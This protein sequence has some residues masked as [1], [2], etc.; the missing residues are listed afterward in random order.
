MGA[1]FPWG[2]Q[3]VMRRFDMELPYH[4]AIIHTIA[5][6]SGHPVLPGHPDLHMTGYDKHSEQPPLPFH[7]Q[8]AVP[9]FIG[10]TIHSTAIVFVQKSV[11]RLD[12]A[13]GAQRIR[14][15]YRIW[16]NV[17]NLPLDKC[18]VGPPAGSRSKRTRVWFATGRGA[19][20][21]LLWLVQQ[22]TSSTMA[23]IF[24]RLKVT[25]DV[26]GP[27]HQ[28]LVPSISTM[29]V[30]GIMSFHWIWTSYYS[31]TTANDL[32]AILFVAILGWDAAEE[33]PPLFGSLADAYTLRRFWGVFW[34]RLHVYSFTLCM[35]S[36]HFS[37]NTLVGGAFGSFWVFT[38]SAWSHAVANSILY[39]QHFLMSELRFFLLNWAVC[40]VETIA[41]RT[42]V[43]RKT[44][45]RGVVAKGLGYGWVFTVFFCIVPAWQ[46]PKLHHYVERYS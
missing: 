46:Y 34:H 7:S 18:E 23:S 15:I 12:G 32:A 21:C 19:R 40:S 22:A 13:S 11:F 27:V 28:G 37:R 39:G 36:L 3:N 2:D 14:A 4:G 10:L 26:F 31:L 33:W 16:S 43:A 8:F 42:L 24:R 9:F 17:R 29:G 25:V 6:R 35:P 45:G 1:D 38:L 41:G 30:C 44:F 20:V 5:S